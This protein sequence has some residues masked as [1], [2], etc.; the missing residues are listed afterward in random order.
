MNMMNYSAN[1][2]KEIVKAA[3][4][5]NTNVYLCDYPERFIEDLH[6]VVTEEAD[7]LGYDCTTLQDVYSN[8][9]RPLRTIEIKLTKRIDC[10]YD[11]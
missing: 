6:T 9:R 2:L 11:L 1:F 10:N 4:R 8:S 3:T 5:A 7:L